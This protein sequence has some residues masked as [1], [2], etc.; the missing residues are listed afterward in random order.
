MQSKQQVE[1][2]VRKTLQGLDE[3]RQEELYVNRNIM[4]YIYKHTHTTLDED[5]TRQQTSI[6]VGKF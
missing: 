2:Y 5:N 1:N 4:R 3:M 6:S